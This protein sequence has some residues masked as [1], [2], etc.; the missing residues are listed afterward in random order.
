MSKNAM[1]VIYV[2]VAVTLALVVI[3]FLWGPIT[4]LAESIG[5]DISSVPLKW[6]Q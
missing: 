1:T 2:A 4:E 5:Q 6:G 3:G